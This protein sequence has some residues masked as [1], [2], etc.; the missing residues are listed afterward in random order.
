MPQGCDTVQSEWFR[1]KGAI[2]PHQEIIEYVK[3]LELRIVRL[4][5]IVKQI[6][7]NANDPW[8]K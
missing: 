6:K 8:Q 7:N 1:T 2:T 5:G 4:E 3:E